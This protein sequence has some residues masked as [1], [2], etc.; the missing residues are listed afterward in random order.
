[1]AYSHFNPAT[2]LIFTCSISNWTK[3]EYYLSIGWSYYN[4]DRLNMSR[5]SQNDCDH[6][7]TVKDFH[8]DFYPSAI[9]AVGYSDHR[10]RA[11]G[12]AVRNSAVTKKLLDEFCLFF[13]DMTLGLCN[14]SHIYFFLHQA[15]SGHFLRWPPKKLVG[16]I[17]Y[18][19]LVGLRSNLVWLFSRYFWWSDY[20]LGWIHWKQ[21]DCRSH[22]KKLTWW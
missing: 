5:S 2:S 7:I 1:M 4:L 22:E 3:R 19:P 10:R 20:F 6:S 21:N 11:V 16:T 12:R 18:E 9:K 8:C 15:I 17:T 14:L 13:T